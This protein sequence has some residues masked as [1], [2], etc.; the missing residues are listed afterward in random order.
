[1]KHFIDIENLR[2]QNIQLDSG[3]V[4]KSNA[5][6]FHVGDEIHVSCKVD[7]SNASFRYNEETG[8]L[9]VFSRK[10]EL[11]YKNTLD[12]FWNFI[13]TYPWD[14][15]ELAQQP[16][17]IY[18]GEWIPRTHIV[19]YPQEMYKQWYVYDIWDT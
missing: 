9:D 2:E 10:R 12:G 5:G 11:D 18:F 3:T 15:E 14:M 13:Q 4:R 6:A 16:N 1:M 17:W 19:Q 7:G 8:K